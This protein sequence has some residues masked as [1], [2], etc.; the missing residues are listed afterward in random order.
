MSPSDPSFSN[1]VAEYAAA[2]EKFRTGND[3]PKEWFAVPDHLAI[4]CAN[5]ADYERTVQE[6]LPYASHISYASINSR[7]LASIHLT[8][9]LAVGNNGEVAWV[10]VMEPRPEKVGK[11][12][13]GIDHMEFLFPDFKAVIT[14]LNAKNIP[15]EADENPLHKWISILANGHEFKLNDQVLAKVVEY[16]LANGLAT[17]IK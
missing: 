17:V 10:E 7:R 11:D 12:P 14:V 16:N 15:F 9:A 2:L 4:K 6:W 13:V 1:T 5:P 8:S 3:L